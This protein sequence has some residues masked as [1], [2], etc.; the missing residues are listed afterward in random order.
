V[1]KGPGGKKR[2]QRDRR[3]GRAGIGPGPAYRPNPNTGGTRHRGN[4]TGN[5]MTA[6]V[7]GAVILG[8]IIAAFGGTAAAL[9]A[10]L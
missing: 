5:C 9:A 6:K 3:P 7:V 10:V 4:T 2:P 1:G 8:L